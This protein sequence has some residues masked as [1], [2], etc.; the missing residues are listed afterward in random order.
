MCAA[1]EPIVTL[2]QQSP[3]YRIVWAIDGKTGHGEWHAD[4]SVLFP[5]VK[6]GNDTFG[7][8]THWIERS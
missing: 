8:G 5:W 1:A 7:A 6:H 3:R 2:V 4:E